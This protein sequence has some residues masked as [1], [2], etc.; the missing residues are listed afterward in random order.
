M[1]SKFGIQCFPFTLVILDVIVD[2]DVIGSVRVVMFARVRVRGGVRGGLRSFVVRA[3]V[4][5]WRL[6][7]GDQRVVVVMMTAVV[8]SA[9]MLVRVLIV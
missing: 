3:D 1:Y 7:S 5:R 9:V 8:A 4:N 2:V 6:S